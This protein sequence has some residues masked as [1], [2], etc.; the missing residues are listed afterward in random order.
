MQKEWSAVSVV[1][2]ALSVERLFFREGLPM[3]LLDMG[4]L[5]DKL[6]S[7]SSTFYFQVDRSPRSGD[8][9]HTVHDIF[10]SGCNTVKRND[11]C[12]K[13]FPSA[14]RDWRVH[15]SNKPVKD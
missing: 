7:K 2:R 5:H 13:I 12:H 15:A 10:R 3:Q 14:E 11:K 9:F 4:L 1:V 6:C 8:E